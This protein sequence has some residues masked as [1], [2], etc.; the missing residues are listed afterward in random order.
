M[1]LASKVCSH[2][3][4]CWENFIGVSIDPKVVGFRVSDN[5]DSNPVSLNLKDLTDTEETLM[6]RVNGLQ[7]HSNPTKNKGL[8]S[9]LKIKTV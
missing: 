2:L 5:M 9:K 3:P 1:S 8:S 7:H 6:L 4:S